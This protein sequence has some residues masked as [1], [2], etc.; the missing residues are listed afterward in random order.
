[1]AKE[2][3]NILTTLLHD[4]TVSNSQRHQRFIAKLF[5]LSNGIEFFFI[6]FALGIGAL[7]FLKI[8]PNSNGVL[9]WILPLL[10]IDMTILGGIYLTRHHQYE[11]PNSFWYLW[12]LLAMLLAG[13][14]WAELF[15]QTL[16]LQAPLSQTAGIVILILMIFMGGVFF[17]VD[18]IVVGSFF[19]SASMVFI[20][21]LLRFPTPIEWQL[22]WLITGT[23]LITL[24][25]FAWSFWQQ[26]LFMRI[27]AELEILR[28]Y[29][30]KTQLDVAKFKERINIQTQQQQ[31]VQIEIKQAKEAAESANIAKT[32]FLATMSHEIRTPLNGIIPILEMLL[33]TNLNREQADSVAT[34]LNSSHHLL[35][36]IND[37]LDY[38]KIESGRLELESIEISISEL[39][40]SVIAL[41]NKSAER[42]NL[43]LQSKIAPDIPPQ[44]RGD[45]FRLRQILTNLV[46]NAI[47][48]TEKGGVSVEVSRYA[49]STREI[50]ML[51]L[52]RDT[53][54]GMSKEAVGQLF[55]LFTQADASTTRKYGGT[56][57]G[58]VICR[59]LVEIMGGRIGVKSE[60]DK[61]SIFWF[62]VP[63][64]KALNEVP[65]ARENLSGAKV[66]LTGFDESEE[67]RLVKYFN[68]WKMPCDQSVAIQD[69][70]NKL[71]TAY[72]LGINSSYDVLML[73]AGS[74]VDEIETLI[75]NI[76]RV[77]E[78]STLA[79]IAVDAFPSLATTLKEIGIFEVI[80]RPVQEQELRSRLH[81][82]LDVQTKTTTKT[83]QR[84][85][86]MPD[87]AYSWEDGKSSQS[88]HLNRKGQV[89]PQQAY[90]GMQKSS[91]PAL[92]DDSPLVGQVLVVEDNPVN[93]SVIKKLLQRFG[94]NA[95]IARDG[96]ES[97]E[98]IKRIQYDVV[99]MDVQMPNMDGFEATKRIRVRE[100]ELGLAHMPILAMTANAMAGDREKCL[101][102]GMDDYISKPVKLADLKNLLRQWLP[103]E[104]SVSI[105]QYAVDHSLNSPSILKP[106]NTQT[107]N[108]QKH[109]VTQQPIVQ[110]T[111]PNIPV[112]K[113]V[114]NMEMLNDLFDVM[115]HETINL[116]QAYIDNVT[117]IFKEIQQGIQQH[118]ATIITRPAHSLKSSSANIGA[119]QVSELAKQLEFIGRENRMDEADACWQA[120]Q[121]AYQQAEQ[122]L[123]AIIKRGKL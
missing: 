105:P 45:P 64:R 97:L 116:L 89:K 10:L 69:V 115:E 9:L 66:L 110:P 74:G 92:P 78:L 96:L 30:D 38:S 54:I 21:E 23:I 112:N 2:V 120:L 117:I 67:Q 43:K 24:L 16:S 85:L 35:N 80:P 70:L 42:R 58:L 108:V 102:A 13:I 95:D 94:L 113:S 114:I 99:L 46:G 12:L 47:K 62:I 55:Q 39:I 6:L 52:V 98:A 37:I 18:L 75:H 72:K 119:M 103:M 7:F 20:I 14:I 79:I 88:Q 53:G 81:R 4:E 104:E 3:L 28:P 19:A 59:R 25:G 1:M 27:I 122:V 26:R 8:I 101:Q 123:R 63:I 36:L 76:R 73:N 51:F 56:G 83:E 107:P 109:T 82:L 57:L 44:V 106:T 84:P 93:L 121:I 50:A 87:A 60:K 68:T 65:S 5:L 91:K 77:F 41:M 86:V 100:Q 90:L 111:P 22:L 118:D 33:E 15:I 71:K 11:T 49:T 31:T 34:A 61:G 40:D 48:F 29:Y 17:A 32:E